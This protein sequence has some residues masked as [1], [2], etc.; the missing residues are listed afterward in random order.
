VPAAPTPAAAAA[1]AVVA[2]VATA[3]PPS[4]PAATAPQP[5]QA[6]SPAPPAAAAR[7]ADEL[8]RSV[9][10]RLRA[11]DKLRSDGLITEAEYQDKRKQLLRDL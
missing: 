7:S 8:Y 2:P 10:E 1:P 9:A 6:I 3:A 11:L 4:K 5:A